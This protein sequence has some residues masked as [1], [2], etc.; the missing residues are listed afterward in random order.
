MS[1][2]EEM[3]RYAEAHSNAQGLGE[4]VIYVDEF[5]PDIAQLVGLDP[6]GLTVDPS[7]LQ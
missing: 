2:E 6:E 3:R 4:E 5:G 1:D 7:L